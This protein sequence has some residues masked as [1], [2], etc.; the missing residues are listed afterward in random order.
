M[1]HNLKTIPPYWTHVFSGAKTFEVRRNDRGFLVGD[2]LS[3]DEWAPEQEN[4]TGRQLA[5]RVDY[6]LD[7][8]AFVKEGFVVMSISIINK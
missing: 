6:I 2:I 4:Y 7:A 8:P 3:L 1:I 5:V